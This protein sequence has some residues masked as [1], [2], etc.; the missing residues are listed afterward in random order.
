M[1]RNLPMTRQRWYRPH[2]EWVFKY[3][4]AQDA[5]QPESVN[6]NTLC[7]RATACIPYSFYTLP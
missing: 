3:V 4:M 6:A 7:G 2:H 5:S 1:A